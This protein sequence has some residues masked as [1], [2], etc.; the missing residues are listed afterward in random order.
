MSNYKQII[1][2]KLMAHP[3]VFYLAFVENKESWAWVGLAGQGQYDFTIINNPNLVTTIQK[4][5]D[6]NELVC[7]KRNPASIPRVSLTVLVQTRSDKS[8]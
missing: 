1:I 4:M 8:S 6:D 7:L 3:G 2:Q 5:I